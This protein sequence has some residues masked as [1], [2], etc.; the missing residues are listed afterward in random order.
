[1]FERDLGM[2]GVGLKA[3]AT[4]SSHPSPIQAQANGS[5]AIWELVNPNP[6]R[7]R[8]APRSLAHEEISF[9]PLPLLGERAGVRGMPLRSPHPAFGHL[10]PGNNVAPEKELVSEFASS[11]GFT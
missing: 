1:M 8:G 9:A 10:L 7:K 11:N 2:H 6:K 4:S 3:V 5:S